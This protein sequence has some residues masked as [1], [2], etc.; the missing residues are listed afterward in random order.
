MS[1]R[2]LRS[3]TSWRGDHVMR[4][5]I[6][7]DEGNFVRAL[8]RQLVS[9]GYTL[10]RGHRVDH[11]AN[12]ATCRQLAS[13]SPSIDVVFMDGDLGL[14][15]EDGPAI[16]QMLRGE[17]RSTARI[18]MTSSLDRYVRAGIEAGADTSVDKVRLATETAEALTTL[19]IPLPVPRP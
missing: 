8:K 16:V 1:V 14:G 11:A 19:G 5:L 9:I 15:D 18:V 17:L 3:F 6:V 10:E 13:Q 4:F 7:D 12:L 2:S